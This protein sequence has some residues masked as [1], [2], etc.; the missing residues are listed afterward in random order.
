MNERRVDL[1][2]DLGES[3]GRY[4]LGEDA[5][6]LEVVTSANVACGFHAGDPGVM[7]ETARAAVARGVAVGAHPGLPDL[8][9]FGRRE[10]RVSPQEAHDLTLYQV[11]A[12]S[13]FVRAAGG[14]LR[15]VKPHGALYN[16]AARDPE[17]AGAVARAVRAFDP[18]LR[19]YGLSNSCLTRAGKQAG[20]RVVHEAFADRAYTPEGQLAPRTSPGALLGPDEAVRQA[21]EMVTRGRVWAQGGRP[22]P[23]RADTICVH[24][25]GARALE[26]AR[27]LRKA[28]E[29][30]G[31]RVAAPD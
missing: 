19:L 11:G 9:G 24:G 15:H 25:D 16:M 10:M 27:A 13:A 29:Q 1:N 21:V 5:A 22:I 26:T 14:Q 8:Q 23:L 28:L 20:L 3:F 12:L 18:G 7:R 4:R 30:R 17:L 6:L 2:S 31:V